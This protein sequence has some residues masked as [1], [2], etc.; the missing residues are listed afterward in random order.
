[1]TNI[2]NV[3]RRIPEVLIADDDPGILRFLADHCAKMGFAV[4]T[5]NNGLQALVMAGRGPPD[6][7][8]VDVN[9]PELD[10]LSVCLRLL[11]PDKKS[12][13]VIVI[14]GGSELE[15]GERCAGFGA[16]YAHK[17]PD[18]WKH[19][20]AALTRFFPDMPG[21]IAEE[22]GSSSRAKAWKRPRVLVVDD[23]ADVE[24]FLSSRLRKC[25][26]DSLYASDGVKGYKMACKEEPSVVLCDYFM[27]N[28]DAMYLL[29]KLRSTR[30]TAGIP[31][32]V[33]SGRPIDKATEQSLMREMC[34]R[35]GALRIFTKPL[36]TQEL[37]AAI[38]SHCAFDRRKIG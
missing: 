12:F 15:L 31:F 23:D 13:Q 16:S 38:Q 5:A 29:W 25:G 33:M 17:G 8:I 22:A 6:V 36:D 27:P 19:V 2:P 10:G 34:G 28:G 37:F 20:Q 18:L 1:V 26:V 32:F 30:P 4:R 9:M 14:S 7:L 3:D 21:T 11:G 35:S 24:A